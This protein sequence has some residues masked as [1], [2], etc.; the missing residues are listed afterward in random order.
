MK[1]EKLAHFNRSPRAMKL[2][3]TFLLSATAFF[4]GIFAKDLAAIMKQYPLWSPVFNWSLLV[5]STMAIAGTYAAIRREMITDSTTQKIEDLTATCALV[6]RQRDIFQQMGSQIGVLITEKSDRFTT[7]S[8]AETGGDKWKALAWALSPQEQLNLI[9]QQ[10]WTFVHTNYPAS[11]KLRFGLYIQSD[12]DPDKLICAFSWDGKKPNCIN[13]SAEHLSISDPDGIKSLVLDCYHK[14]GGQP[15]III[16]DTIQAS[17]E[18]RFNFFR[19][20][21]REYLKSIF[22][23]KYKATIEERKRPMI[24]SIDSSI[25]AFFKEKDEDFLKGFLLEMGR[26]MEY[27]FEVLYALQRLSKS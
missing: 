26:R 4:T 1:F 12:D 21:Q 17:N 25:P 8:L 15:S 10:I 11:E 16:S 19:P 22:V 13:S 18:G 9:V 6:T 14:P 24:F 2:G 20:A 5:L 23:M 3:L 7:C 27:E